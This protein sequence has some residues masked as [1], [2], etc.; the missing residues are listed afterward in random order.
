MKKPISPASWST[1]G[2]FVLECYR[3]AALYN[4]P[5]AITRTEA[6]QQVDAMRADGWEDLPDGLDAGSFCYWWN[7]FCDSCYIEH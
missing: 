7:S 5:R 4:E 2:D 3:D 6:A 1:V